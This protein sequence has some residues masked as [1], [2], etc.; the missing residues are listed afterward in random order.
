MTLD[1]LLI[2]ITVAQQKNLTP[3]QNLVLRGAWHGQTYTRIAEQSIY[4]AD[5]L[6]T[7]AARLWQMMS[8]L[9]NLPITKSTFRSVVESYVLTQEQIA[10]IAIYKK[11]LSQSFTLGEAKSKENW[12]T[13]ESGS[14]SLPPSSRGGIASFPV[15][16]DSSC[17]NCA[18]FLEYP[19]GPVALE[20]PFYI[21]RPPLE[22]TA[23]QEITKPGSILRIKASKQM[24]KSSL[25]LRIFAQ[26]NLLGYETVTIDF[27]QADELIISDLDKFLRWFCRIV[28]QKLSIPA[29]L[30]HFWETAMGS[31]VNCTLYLQNYLL[32]KINRPLVLAFNEL[33]RLFKHPKITQEFLTIVRSWSEEGQKFDPWR[34]LR[35]VLLYSQEIYGEEPLYISDLSIGLPLTL[36]DFTPEQVNELAALHRLPW[37]SAKTEQLMAMVGG[38]PALIRLAFYHLVNPLNLETESMTL[39]RLLVWVA[40]PLGIYRDHLYDL[41]RHLQENPELNRAFQSVLAADKPISI[42]PEFADRLASLGLVKIDA[43]FAVTVRCQLYRLYFTHQE[44]SEA[45]CCAEYQMAE[46]KISLRERLQQL[47]QEYAQ[48]QQFCHRDPLTNLANQ[49]GFYQYIGAYWPEFIEHKLPVSLI[50]G[51]LDFFNFYNQR[52]GDR[53]GNACLK[54]I[55]DLLTQTVDYP[56]KIVA[57]FEPEEFVILLP[58]VAADEALQVAEKI[59]EMVKNLGLAHDHA[60]MGGLPDV[61]TMS[62]GVTSIQ[63]NAQNYPDSLIITANMALKKSKKQG[64]DRTFFESV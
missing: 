49:L 22:R 48:N 8:H 15:P 52:Y 33:N 45:S 3:A 36:T 34:N 62:L 56:G 14:R 40:T 28:S 13:R 64:G 24:G 50:V 59:R 7:T 12:A 16:I 11:D 30:E 57:R 32:T 1:Q 5:Y 9:L 58:G 37:N 38:H 21:E 41:R 20:S 55:A 60:W 25:L 54:Q 39:E 10:L 35:F 51:N 4:E 43:N 31:K 18:D 53:T 61:L 27:S 46:R 29:N 47:E 2:L 23:Y 44:H 63:A 6:K 17:S 42:M 26:A 19:S